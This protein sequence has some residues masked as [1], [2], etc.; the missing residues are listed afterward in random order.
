MNDILHARVSNAAR[1][2]LVLAYLEQPEARIIAA[3]IIA[4]GC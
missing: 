3:A 4:R 2:L 1:H